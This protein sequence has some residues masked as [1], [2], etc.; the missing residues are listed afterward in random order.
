MLREML[1]DA[2]EAI[3]TAMGCAAFVAC[4]ILLCV[5]IAG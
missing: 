4:A 1:A 5:G 2:P 3:V